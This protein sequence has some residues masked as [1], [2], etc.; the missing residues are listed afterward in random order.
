MCLIHNK[1]YIILQSIIKYFCSCAIGLDTSRDQMRIFPNFQ[2]W[3]HCERYLKDNK[4]H[5]LHLG[6]KYALILFLLGSYLLL[7]AHSFPQAT[8]SQDCSLLRTDNVRGQKP[9]NIFVPNEGYCLYGLTIQSCVV[10]SLQMKYF[11]QK[12]DIHPS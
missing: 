4:H 5:S 8:L 6:W 1:N 11:Y 2:Y 7:E 3:V 10:T 9:L 12:N